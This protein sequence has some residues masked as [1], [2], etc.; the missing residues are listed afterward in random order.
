MGDLHH[1]GSTNTLTGKRRSKI[2]RK[3]QGE[4]SVGDSTSENPEVRS[5]NQ[6]NRK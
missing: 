4:S 1:Q 3:I 5:E 6:I 2:A